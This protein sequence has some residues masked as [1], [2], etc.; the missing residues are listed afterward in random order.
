M[1]LFA[2]FAIVIAAMTFAVQNAPTVTI[3]LF[4]WRF[5]APLA[6]VIT[7]CFAAGVLVSLLA[8]VP[9]LYRLYRMRAH[10]RLLTAQVADLEAEETRHARTRHPHGGSQAPLAH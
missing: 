4:F 6:L 5:D 7:A 10:E 9:H 3:N 8:S 1:R 2:V